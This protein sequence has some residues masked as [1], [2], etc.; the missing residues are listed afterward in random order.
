MK[1]VAQILSLMFLVYFGLSYSIAEAKNSDLIGTVVSVNLYDSTF[2]NGENYVQAI[3]GGSGVILDEYGNIATNDHVIDIEGVNLEGDLLIIVCIGRDFYEENRCSYKTNVVQQYDD[4]DL[5]FL[6]ITG[7]ITSQGTF[8]IKPYEFKFLNHNYIKWPEVS[9]SINDSITIIGYPTYT[10]MYNPSYELGELLFRPKVEAVKEDRADY[11]YTNANV[12]FGNS[13]GGAFGPDDEFLGM[14]TYIYYDGSNDFAG[15]LRYDFIKERYEADIAPFIDKTVVDTDSIA[16][17]R[18]FE[19]KELSFS[20][21]G[22]FHPYYYSSNNMYRR[23]MLNGYDDNT[24]KPYNNINRAEFSKMMKPVI[25]DDYWDESLSNCFPDVKDEWFAE[26]V[27]NLKKLGY[28]D[29][30]PDGNF[31]PSQNIN[32]AEASKI[33]SSIYINFNTSSTPWYEQYVSYI[34]EQN[35]IP[36]SIRSFDQDLTREEV[37]A[38]I[39]RILFTDDPESYL[40]YEDINED[41]NNRIYG[42]LASMERFKEVAS[43]YENLRFVSEEIV[44]ENKAGS[45]E[46]LI[47]CDSVMTMSEFDI[48]GENISWKMTHRCDGEDKRNYRKIRNGYQIQ[49]LDDNEIYEPDFWTL[50]IDAKA[51]R[52]LENLEYYSHMIVDAKRSGNTYTVE[53]DPLLGN[54]TRYENNSISS[55]EEALGYYNANE[56]GTFDLSITFDDEGH[57]TN[58]EFSNELEDT[59]FQRL[60]EVE[61]LDYEINYDFK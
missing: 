43:G 20:D 61:Y 33:L 13:G 2:I 38:L 4:L 42:F 11:Y 55:Y 37:V 5:A 57:L 24:L 21:V 18:T 27:C 17:M 48:Y 3:S 39:Y 58:Y 52:V 30:Y 56:R 45:Y 36:Y 32:F 44:V 59:V 50:T 15:I 10:D 35:S 47:S 53:I 49:T 7:I 31:K 22:I 54:A 41:R 46:V 51:F 40:K 26:Y 25:N 23:G 14:P 29:G 1:R 9:P 28:I 8:N 34:D 60:V 16:K 12:T 19:I 6:Q